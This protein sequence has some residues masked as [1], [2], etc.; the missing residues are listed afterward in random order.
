MTAQTSMAYSLICDF[1]LGPLGEL[2]G[3]TPAELCRAFV[4]RHGLIPT[5]RAHARLSE[6]L[7]I[8]RIAQRRC[9]VTGQ[10]KAPYV[11]ATQVVSRIQNIKPEG[12]QHA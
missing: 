9:A 4:A 5:R 2:Q 12:A 8:V 3:L 10:R 11:P 6:D 1:A 7:L